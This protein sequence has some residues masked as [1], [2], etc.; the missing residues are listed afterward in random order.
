MW[1]SRSV[2]AVKSNPSKYY[3]HEIKNKIDRLKTVLFQFIIVIKYLIINFLYS[4]VDN[5][6][7]KLYTKNFYSGVG[8]VR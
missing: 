4:L 5:R 2:S 6:T 3:Y 7:I 1:N 8:N